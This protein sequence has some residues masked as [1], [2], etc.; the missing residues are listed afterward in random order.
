MTRSALGD[1]AYERAWAAGRALSLDDAVA[2]ALRHRSADRPERRN[3]RVSHVL[4]LL[5][6]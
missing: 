2:E 4:M 3:A 6:R 1:E 5:R